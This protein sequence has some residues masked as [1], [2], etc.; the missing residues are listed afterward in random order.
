MFKELIEKDVPLPPHILN[1]WKKRTAGQSLFEKQNSY[2]S[3]ESAYNEGMQ[4][5][6]RIRL[7]RILL[8]SKL[9]SISEISEALGMEIDEVREIE[10][11]M[12]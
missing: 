10:A 6:R 11:S 12:N 7:A 4:S 3:L 1:S 5:G 2:A 9:C 8:S